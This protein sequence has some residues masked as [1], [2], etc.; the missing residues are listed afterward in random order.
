MGLARNI[1][2][3][4]ISHNK[5]NCM[6]WVHHTNDVVF[7]QDTHP[8]N[9]LIFMYRPNTCTVAYGKEKRNLEAYYRQDPT[10]IHIAET[11]LAICMHIYIFCSLKHHTNATQ[12][13]A[14]TSL[15][16]EEAL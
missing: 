1:P 12:L 4:E 9:C 7:R 5:Q 14:P 15:V 6:H 2:E 10:Y 16:I 13:L 3:N 8:T 11:P